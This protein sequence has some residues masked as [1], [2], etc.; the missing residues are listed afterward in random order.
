MGF[1]SVSWSERFRS[2]SDNPGY[3]SCSWLHT[4][5]QWWDDIAE[6]ITHSG[7]RTQR[8]QETNWK[9][10]PCWLASLGLE[11]L[12]RHLGAGYWTI[13]VLPSRDSVCWG[14]YWTARQHVPL[15]Q[16]RWA[17]KLLSHWIWDS[18]HKRVFIHAWY[19]KPGLLLGR[20][21]GCF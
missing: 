1:V 19:Y 17:T 14:Q 4:M 13:T 20:C 18:L 10:P 15:M 5:T 9:F 16:L 8:Y 11:F 21:C 3:C 7:C 6:D 12:W 2:L